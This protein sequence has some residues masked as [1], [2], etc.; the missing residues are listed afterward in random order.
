MSTDLRYPIGK[1]EPQASYTVPEVRTN[2]K[3]LDKFPS[4][5]KQLV[6]KLS[7]AQLDTPYRPDGW[8]VR[9]VVHHVA[10]SHAN[11]VI[12]VKLALTEENPTI[13]PYEEQDWA[14]LDDYAMPIKLS[15][16]IIEGLHKRMVVALKKA[17]KKTLARTYYHPA[18]G[19]KSTLAE[20]V[21]MYVWHSEHHY[22]HINQLMI[23]E[24][25]V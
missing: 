11:M 22:Q 18:N 9:Q 4:K 8:T 25:W 13:K 19:R 7:D 6:A 16:N 2:L 14:K 20:V 12:R 23:R 17:D 3:Y 24:G 1:F 10:D 21:A 5:L 15:L